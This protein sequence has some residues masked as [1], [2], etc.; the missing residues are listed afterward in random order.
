MRPLCLSLIFSAP[1][2]SIPAHA[3]RSRMSTWRLEQIEQAIDSLPSLSGLCQI[4]RISKLSVALRLVCAALTLSWM[5]IVDN[6]EKS[7]KL[8]RRVGAHN[9][10]PAAR[11]ISSLSKYFD[12]QSCIIRSPI[13]LGWSYVQYFAGGCS[14][15]TVEAGRLF[16][17]VPSPIIGTSTEAEAQH[18][19]FC[20]SEDTTVKYLRSRFIGWP[21]LRSPRWAIMHSWGWLL[22][23]DSASPEAAFAV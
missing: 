5:D 15:A 1:N 16:H 18:V 11:G 12:V 21:T 7:P 2:G 4:Y 14:W 19:D 10:T 22:R 8:P 17:V 13:R 9:G 3:L 20:P 6:I 23:P